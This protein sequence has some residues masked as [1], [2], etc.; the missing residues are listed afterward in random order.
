M[1]TNEKIKKLTNEMGS[2]NINRAVAL[3]LNDF[4]QLRQR[5]EAPALQGEDAFEYQRELLADFL[6]R[7][8]KSLT[9]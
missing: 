8:Q 3:L 7:L 4:L 6:E 9:Q 2:D 1:D 5:L